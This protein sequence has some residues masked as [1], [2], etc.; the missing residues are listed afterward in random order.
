[1]CV[2][3][4]DLE[5]ASN[6]WF[7]WVLQLLNL[8]HLLLLF[9]PL[10]INLPSFMLVYAENTTNNSAISNNTNIA[11]LAIFYYPVIVIRVESCLLVCFLLLLLIAIQTYFSYFSRCW[12]KAHASA[13]QIPKVHINTTQKHKIYKMKECF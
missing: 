10:S 9:S 2:Y 4:W 8:Y 1:M 7:L 11:S 3:L 5:L 12:Q 6:Y 13:T